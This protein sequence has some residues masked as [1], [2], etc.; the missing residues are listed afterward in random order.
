MSQRSVL[1]INGGF[2]EKENYSKG[3]II[4]CVFYAF[5]LI[6]SNIL[7]GKAIS[8]LGLNLT[9]GILV[10]PVVYILSDVM[11]EVY[12]IKKSIF[13]IRM[14]TVCCIA[15]VL[16][17]QLMLL[18]PHAE[19]WKGQEAYELVFGSAP[20]IFAA[21]L[22]SY[23]FGDWLNSALLS[24]LKRIQA[25]KGF[26]YRAIMSSVFAHGIDSLLFYSIAFAGVFP[27]D[28]LVG[29]GF[30]QWA[31]KLS[32]EIICLPL[33]T[34][35]VNAWKRIE[36]IDVTDTGDLAIYNPFQR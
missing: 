14:N 12:G 19:W 13:A 32:Y 31:F 2:M 3:F 27:A 11:T 28:V 5:F 7:T 33:T 6:L 26:G 4:L 35:I 20:R 1:K 36:G 18:I 24:Y 9:A 29:L 16:F 10:F 21:S 25:D 22:A 8:F 34:R 30:T 15:F 17:T 23:Y